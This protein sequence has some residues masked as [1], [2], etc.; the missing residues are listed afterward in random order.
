MPIWEVGKTAGKHNE[1]LMHLT[2]MPFD[3]GADVSTIF[4]VAAYAHD[5][6]ICG[7]R[8]VVSVS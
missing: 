4:D 1:R 8:I 7:Y 6:S 3:Q 2:W 5:G